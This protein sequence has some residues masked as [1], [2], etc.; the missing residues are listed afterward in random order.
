MS[1]EIEGSPEI[2][3]KIFMRVPLLSRGCFRDFSRDS[4]RHSFSYCSRDSIG[5]SSEIPTFF[6]YTP[7]QISLMIPLFSS[8]GITFR[9]PPEILS[10]IPFDTHSMTLTG[11]LPRILPIFYFSYDSFR[12]SFK[13]SSRILQGLIFRLSQGLLQ[14]FF[15][16]CFRVSPGIPS[17]KSPG[18]CL[19]V[20]FGI[21]PGISPGIFAG[22]FPGK[23]TC[24]SSDV[25]PRISPGIFSEYVTNN[26]PGILARITLCEEGERE[27][28]DS[29]NKIHF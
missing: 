1:L 5:V 26:S 21:A 13:Y 3:S 24:I 8:P 10:V 29:V 20:P 27:F 18:I 11:I 2:F 22:I 16:D 14:D 12:Y 9:A 15:M 19:G 28:V 17:E 6:M 25:P 4:F 7:S 23:F